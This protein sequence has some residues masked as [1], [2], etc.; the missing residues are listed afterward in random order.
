MRRA[1][2]RFLGKAAQGSPAR[3][4]DMVSFFTQRCV[5]IGSYKSS[6]HIAAYSIAFSAQRSTTEA[7]EYED[8]ISYILK[9]IM[10]FSF[11]SELMV[12]E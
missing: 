9:C 2:F 7:L 6:I 12:Q 1:V 5:L 4:L 3:A 11:H 10:C 8:D